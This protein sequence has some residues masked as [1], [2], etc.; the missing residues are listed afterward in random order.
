MNRRRSPAISISPS[1]RRSDIC[2]DAQ[3]R[4]GHVIFLYEA[5]YLSAGALLFIKFQCLQF[6]NIVGL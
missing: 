1:L 5:E 6:T 3:G 4:F 2:A